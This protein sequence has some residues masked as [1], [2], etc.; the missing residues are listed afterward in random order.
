[1]KRLLRSVWLLVLLA[2][3]GC[4]PVLAPVP[5]V[6]APHYPDFVFPATP[7]GLARGQLALRQQ[8]GWQFLQAG[9]L[10]GARHEFGAVLRSSPTFFPAE[11]GLAYVSLADKDFADA[12]RRFD[13][14]L[15]Q[16]AGYVPALVGK[17]DAQ[18][19]SGRLDEAAASYR[20]ALASEPSFADVRRRLDVIAFRGQQEALTRA[21]QA[22]D[23]G[24]YD[25][26]AAGYERAIAASPDSAWL[27]RELA[28]IER[29]QGQ[30]DQALARL[31]RA[32]TLDPSDAR[33]L[34]SMGELMEDRADYAGAADAYTRAQVLEPG[35]EVAGRLARVRSQLDLA[36][37]PEA[38]RQ[39]GASPQ[40]TRGDLAAV[41]GVRLSAFLLAAPKQEAVV[42]TDVR[43]H[44]AAPWIMM[45][46]RAGVIDPYPNHTFAPRGAIK[47]LDL[48]HVV[49]RVLSII[50]ARRPGLGS[51]W[52]A[53]RPRIVDLPPGHL[54]Y[55]AAAM[56][57]AADAMPLLEG[58][59]FKPTR[60]VSGAEVLDV[61]GR[62]EV[63]AR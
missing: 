38:Y 23:A 52:R 42:V 49:N 28:G 41:L 40:I 59:A 60:P 8:R 15:G 9:D 45:V 63:L 54:G 16:A 25:E 33:T 47:R 18:A 24:R 26:A 34:M 11:A 30:E 43:R 31:Q 3:S 61:V 13:A 4:A 50:A 7:A 12:I 10:R 32:V 37:L 22:A 35:D 5:V 62:L 17:G 39:I 53:A 2:V 36:R 57:V 20:A 48:A 55:S 46:V 6:L 21:K 58:G 27:Y 44:W 14:V 29:R 1:M 19:A 51:Q 56:A